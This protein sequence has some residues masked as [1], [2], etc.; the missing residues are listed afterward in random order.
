MALW[1]KDRHFI[2]PV[3][4]QRGTM[5]SVTSRLCRAT[6]RASAAR[7]RRRRIAVTSL[8]LLLGAAGLGAS[9][10]A[11]RADPVVAPNRAATGPA[12]LT[13]EQ[14]QAAWPG[15]EFREC[16]SGCPVM[17]VMPAGKFIMGAPD[18]DPDR[19]AS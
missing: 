12:P 3:T 2:R 17:L 9:G 14:E 13:T 15:S 8:T 10:D 5:T 11:A 18:S 7:P 4:A 1:P 16:G 19:E 6:T